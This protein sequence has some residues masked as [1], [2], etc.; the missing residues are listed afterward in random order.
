MMHASFTSEN[1][2]RLEEGKEKVFTQNC[3]LRYIPSDQRNV[4]RLFIS[5]VRKFMLKT[6][7]EIE[8]KPQLVEFED[9]NDDLDF[10]S[11]DDSSMSSSHSLMENTTGG[12][13]SPVKYRIAK[14]IGELADTSMQYHRRKYLDYIERSKQSSQSPSSRARRT[15]NHVIF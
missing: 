8:G 3:K 12:V 9:H 7:T 1:N 10:V 4:S 14:P 6:E 15:S 5:N 13:M 11:L 2:R